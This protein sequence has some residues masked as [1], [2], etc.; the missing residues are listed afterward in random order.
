MR[1]SASQEPA[2]EHHCQADQEREEADFVDAVHHPKVQPVPFAFL[3]EVEGV[4]VVQKLLEEHGVGFQELAAIIEISTRAPLGRA[5]TATAS[6]AGYGA[7]I[8]SR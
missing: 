7:G 6:R 8:A 5:W 1:D 3:E 2:V 4:E